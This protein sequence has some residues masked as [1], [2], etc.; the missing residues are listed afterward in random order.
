MICSMLDSLVKWP[1]GLCLPLA[2]Q[3]IIDRTSRALGVVYISVLGKIHVK[4]FLCT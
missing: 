3:I 2:L 1:L 4:P